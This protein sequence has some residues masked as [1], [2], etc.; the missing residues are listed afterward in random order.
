MKKSITTL[1]VGFAT[2]ASLFAKSPDEYNI[3]S[4]NIR[5]DTPNDGE[6]R[7]DNRKNEAINVIKLYDTDILGA[8]EVLY[9]QLRDMHKGL[10]D[11]A[12]VSAGREN[13]KK[14]GESVPIFFK[15]DRFTLINSGHFWLSQNKDEIGS[16]GWD[17][18]HPRIS[19]WVILEDKESQKQLF[20][21]NVHLDH[22]GQEARQKGCFLLLDQISTL[23]EDRPVIMLGDFNALRT[24]EP[25]RILSNNQDPRSLKDTR[26]FT[27]E[28][29]G[30]EWTFHNFNRTPIKDRI[31]I[32]YIFFKGNVDVI[33]HSVVNESL[34]YGRCLSDHCPIISTI[35][36][37]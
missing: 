5:L 21:I 26:T 29:Y 12:Y 2:M 10:K 15:K 36:L 7:W 24:D 14:K 27:K 25:I 22:M 18:S 8:Q 4:F 37:Q 6:N 13:G 23:S 33:R 17:G 3:M 34:N 16:I 30:P 32:D 19:T 9:N 20:V 35:K 11:Y 28:T 31:N 1:V